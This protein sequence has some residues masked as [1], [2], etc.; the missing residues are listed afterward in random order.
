MCVVEA[1]L[2]QCE[3]IGVYRRRSDKRFLYAIDVSHINR[4]KHLR[5]IAEL[6][7]FSERECL[8]PFP[9]KMVF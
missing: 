1:R 2:Q 6:F 8:N 7:S 9:S 3:V 5:L 4:S